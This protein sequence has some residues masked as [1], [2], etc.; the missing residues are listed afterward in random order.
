MKGAG[1]SGSYKGAMYRLPLYFIREA[2]EYAK[3]QP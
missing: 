2:Q 3:N 1:T